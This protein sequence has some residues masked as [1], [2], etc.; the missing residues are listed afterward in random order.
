M[1]KK[2]PISG[3]RNPG[4]L[5]PTF[6]VD[7]KVL[8]EPHENS[9]DFTSIAADVVLGSNGTLYITG[10][11]TD[12]TNIR[13]P[14]YTISALHPDGSLD[15][16]FNS[17][18]R[19]LGSYH[20]PDDPTETVRS[21]ANKIAFIEANANDPAKLLVLG[22]VGLLNPGPGYSVSFYPA[23]ARYTLDGHLDNTFG[24]LGNGHAIFPG[25]EGERLKKSSFAG[26]AVPANA[27]ISQDKPRD[28]IW[29]QDINVNWARHNGKIYVMGL[30]ADGSGTVVVCFHD[31]GLVDWSFGTDGMVILKPFVPSGGTSPWN[32][33]MKAM[34]PTEKGLLLGGYSG[35][36]GLTA[37]FARVTYDGRL[38]GSFGKDGYEYDMNSQFQRALALL[39]TRTGHILAAGMGVDDEGVWTV[40]GLCGIDAEGRPDKGFNNGKPLLSSMM[41][42]GEAW[43]GVADADGKFA[44]IGRY[45]GPSEQGNVGGILVG[46][47]LPHGEFD[48]DF[49]ALESDGIRKGWVAFPLLAD[50]D[51]SGLLVEGERIFVVGAELP[52]ESS[53]HSAYI[54]CVKG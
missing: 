12:L 15:A 27:G 36:R 46:R 34:H 29:P 30:K 48:P 45:A 3:P 37:L 49:G 42:R 24:E 35:E 6:G 40:G 2:S 5:D 17:D 10:T 14:Y 8:L 51:A 53:K 38:D 52:P 54:M 22:T 39:A 23:L 11:A 28:F 20:Q 7:G 26:L 43:T 41:R 33:Q 9:S 4:D 21:S 32:V 19:L 13:Q 50:V 47:F 18:G 31:N 1:T 44:V 16:R 25:L